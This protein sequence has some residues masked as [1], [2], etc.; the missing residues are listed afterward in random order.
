MDFMAIQELERI[1]DESNDVDVESA[2]DELLFFRNDISNHEM[3][4]D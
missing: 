4:Y 1:I 3:F 2:M